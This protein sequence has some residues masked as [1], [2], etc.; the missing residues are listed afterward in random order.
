MGANLTLSSTLCVFFTLVAIY[1]ILLRDKFWWA[2]AISTLVSFAAL[3]FLS[4]GFVLPL[5]SLVYLPVAVTLFLVFK[6]KKQRVPSV[7]TLSTCMALILAALLTLWIYFADGSISL[8]AF[9]AFFDTLRVEIVSA[10]STA[11]VTAGETIGAGITQSDA[12]SLATST[13]G[14]TFNLFPAIV[15]II[16]FVISFITHSLYISLVSVN[17]DDQKEIANAVTFNMSVTSAVLFMIAYILALVLSYEKL[18]LYAVAAQNIYTM[19]F[20]GF[21]MITFGFVGSIVKS[22]KAACLGTLL[23]IGMFAMLFFMTGVTLVLASFAGAILVIVAAIK[24]KT[25]KK[26]SI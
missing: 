23:Y 24:Q 9:K 14:M 20:P 2:A 7:A 22:G 25:N 21:T 16:L 10:M 11:L 1:A 19:L 8:S 26:N 15:A 17:L 18:G 12:L 3:L 13:V 5:L 6:Q 4:K